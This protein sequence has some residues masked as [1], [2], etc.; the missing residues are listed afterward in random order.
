MKD[1]WRS[2]LRTWAEQTARSFVHKEGVLGV[3]IGGS[4]ARGQEWRHSDLELGI[5]MDQKN[6]DMPYFNVVGGC[7]VEAIQLAAGDLKAQ[8]KQVAEGDLTPVAHFPIQLYRTRVIHDPT[9]IL[10]QFKQVFDANLFQEMVIRIKLEELKNHIQQTL[11]EARDL[12]AGNR[13]T[14]S[15]VRL[16]YAMNETILSAYWYYRELPRSQNR[17]DSRLR[18]LCER[19]HNPEFYALYREVFNLSNTSR[20]LKKTLPHVKDQV[21][22]ITRLWGDSA[23]DFFQFAVDSDF[24]WRQN[25]GILT[26]YRLYVPI[27]GGAQGIFDHLDQS[28]WQQ[29]NSQLLAFLGLTDVKAEQVDAMLTRVEQACEFFC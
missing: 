19:H 13:P 17:T 22:E 4:L 5:L 18:R 23:H 7:G 11:T 12:L 8:L 29:N 27:I 24:Q 9:G 21:L 15:L 16:R 26:V 28:D 10:T 6:P 25:A 2:D 14:G 3:V 20:I 1:T